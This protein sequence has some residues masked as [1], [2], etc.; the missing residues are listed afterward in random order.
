MSTSENNNNNGNAK[1]KRIDWDKKYLPV[2]IEQLAD[3][4]RQGIKPTFRGMYYTLVDL[5]ILPKTEANYSAL[6]KASVRWRENHLIDMDSFDDT[7]RSIVKDFV[8]EYE[9]HE[10]YV[11]WGIKYL[12]YAKLNYKIPLWYK[13]PHYVEIWLEKNAAVGTFKSIVK[14]LEVVVVPNR[15][16]SSVAFINDNIQN[17][18]DKQAGE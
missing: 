3:F 4:E 15:G 18:K 7:T 9:S 14:D 11:D 1:K 13:Q 10:D 17:L 16:H 6:N 8:D 2:V 12:K 5:G